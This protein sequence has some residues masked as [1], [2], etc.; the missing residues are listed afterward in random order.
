MG[1]WGFGVLDLYEGNQIEVGMKSVTYRL[2]L[3]DANATLQDET[4]QALIAKAI[5]G[6]H[7]K[8]GVQAR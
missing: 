3:Q 5:T 6:L 7:T 1:F 8:F 2:R 4:V